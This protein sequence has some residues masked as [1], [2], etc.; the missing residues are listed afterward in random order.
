MNSKML[1]SSSLLLA[2]L[3]AGSATLA[4]QD[5]PKS[6]GD[7]PMMAKW[8][9]YATPGEAHKALESNVGKWN[10]KVKH[11]M[12]PGEPAVESDATSEV[13]WIMDNHF[14][15]EKVSGKMMDMPYTG[16]GTW[17]YDN[18]KKKYVSTWVDNMNTAI[19]NAEGTYD[20]ASKTFTFTGECPDPMTGKYGKSRSVQKFTD[21]DHWTMQGFHTGPDG[22]EALGMELVATRAK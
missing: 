18:M 12:K 20:A 3:T 21:N 14:I 16:L 9:E 19:L 22:K 17:G 8:M 5:K 11:Y 1:I 6:A 15:Q 2:A 7:D 10:V 4:V 13:V